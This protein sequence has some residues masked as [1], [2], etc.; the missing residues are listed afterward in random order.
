LNRP[1]LIESLHQQLA[2][3][4][5]TRDSTADL[6]PLHLVFRLFLGQSDLR[7]VKSRTVSLV[8]DLLDALIRDDLTNTAWLIEHL[9][10][11]ELVTSET[12]PDPLT[13]SRLDHC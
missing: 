3:R 4:H 5:L 1:D 2:S 12:Q 6:L 11:R 10:Q 7:M 9:E 13:S 8:N